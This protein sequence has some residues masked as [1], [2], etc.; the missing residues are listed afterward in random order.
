MKDEKIKGTIQRRGNTR[1]LHLSSFIF[2]LFLAGCYSFTGASI[3]AH[4]HTIGV[5]LVEDNS[6]FG[7]SAVRQELTDELVQKFTNEG[8]LRVANRSV[9]DAVIESSI[10][11]RGIMDE[12][13]S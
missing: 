11:V 13:V 1:L 3:P 4:I 5:P 7:Q 9:A 6:G 8:S 10:P 12:P 2:H